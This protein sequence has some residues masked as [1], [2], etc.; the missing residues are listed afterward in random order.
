MYSDGR[1]GDRRRK[2]DKEEIELNRRFCVQ[3]LNNLS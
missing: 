1:E 3:K 2:R